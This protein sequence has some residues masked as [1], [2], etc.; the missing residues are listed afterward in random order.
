MTTPA[1]KD[2]V[3]LIAATRRSILREASGLMADSG[4]PLV[5]QYDALPKLSGIA[6][7]ALE[8]LKVA[9]EELQAANVALLEQR[10]E[11]DDRVQHY[12]QLFDYAPFPFF[13]TDIYGTVQEINRA[14]CHLLQRT[15]QS[16]NRKPL[17]TLIP[18]P[19]REKFRQRLNH[20]VSTQV[21]H[22]WDITFARATDG[23]VAVSAS[24]TLVPGLGTTRSGLLFWMLRRSNTEG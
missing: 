2:H 24:V 3:E 12:R 19:E 21:V 13:V 8:E 16:L 9:E 14:A 5:E 18:R 22:L 17:A 20:A 1:S 15:A 6:L 7:S 10:Q 23:P 11:L 4:I